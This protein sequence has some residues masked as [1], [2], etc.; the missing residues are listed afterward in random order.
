MCEFLQGIVIIMIIT[1]MNHEIF[2]IAHANKLVKVPLTPVH[3]GKYSNQ[4]WSQG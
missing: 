1:L 4:V 3:Y 2:V